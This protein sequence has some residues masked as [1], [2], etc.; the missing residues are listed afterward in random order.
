MCGGGQS[1]LDDV[2]YTRK[3]VVLPAQQVVNTKQQV[4]ASNLVLNKRV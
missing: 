4:V 3:N 2:D 1:S